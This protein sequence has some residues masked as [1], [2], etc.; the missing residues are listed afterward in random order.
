MTADHLAP[1]REMTVLL[2]GDDAE[3]RASLARTL[4]MFFS[5]VLTSLYNRYAG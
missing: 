5:R 2:A 1:L 4:G 3:A